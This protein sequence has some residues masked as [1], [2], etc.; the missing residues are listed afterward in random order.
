MMGEETPTPVTPI[1]PFKPWSLIGEMSVQLEDLGMTTLR[2]NCL[3]YVT[4][5]SMRQAGG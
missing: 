2:A 4:A 5:P 1:T 3:V